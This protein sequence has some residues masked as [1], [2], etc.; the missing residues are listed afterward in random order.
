MKEIIKI[1]NDPIDIWE[2]VEPMP[3][4]ADQYE[5]WQAT[6]HTV[7][8]TLGE[9]FTGSIWGYVESEEN[10][11]YS[12]EYASGRYKLKAYPPQ[13]E[14]IQ[15]IDVLGDKVVQWAG[16]HKLPFVGYVY[17]D[18]RREYSLPEGT[19]WIIIPKSKEQLLSAVAAFY[20]R[21]KKKDEVPNIIG[22]KDYLVK[23]NSIGKITDVSSFIPMRK[24]RAEG[25]KRP[26]A[27]K[28]KIE[29]F[30]CSAPDITDEV[31]T[32][33]IVNK[34]NDFF[35]DNKA[36][37][38]EGIKE[39]FRNELP[40]TIGNVL[41]QIDY[42]IE[43]RNL[44][45]LMGALQHIY[46]PEA[47]RIREKADKIVEQI[48]KTACNRVCNLSEF[49][50]D[51]IMHY[52]LNEVYKHREDM[53]LSKKLNN[54]CCS[55]H[56]R[57]Y[58]LISCIET[59]NFPPFKCFDYRYGKDVTFAPTFEEAKAYND[60]ARKTEQQ[61]SDGTSNKTEKLSEPKKGCLL[62]IILIPSSVLS[63]LFSLL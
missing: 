54:L 46:S 14:I 4:F 19:I 9:D 28:K 37:A 7:Y 22:L 59:N 10:K 43:D 26:L 23:S 16:L 62:W 33:A 56:C 18:K 11:D 40:L 44:L 39:T 34:Y 32:Q 55:Y 12:Y 35:I 8:Q 58:N 6:L 20:K 49:A 17:K 24:R 1:S 36:V 3:Q 41:Q 52:F 27:T 51:E 53:A 29:E 13:G 48:Y 5:I 61:C 2:L 45:N 31:L 42:L 60:Q 63:L 47:K 50:D 15:D 57:K 21:R 30:R 25:K 38:E